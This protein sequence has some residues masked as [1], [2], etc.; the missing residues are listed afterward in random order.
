MKEGHGKF[1]KDITF[2]KL[3]CD[4][5]LPEMHDVICQQLSGEI[6]TIFC[7]NKVMFTVIWSQ[8][9]FNKSDKKKDYVFK[10]FKLEVQNESQGG[11]KSLI[12]TS[13]GL[14]YVADFFYIYILTPNF[15]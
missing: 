9:D 1:I 10:N 12:K 6:E 13:S 11:S 14:P 15:N 4:W 5:N 7:T 8:M 2:L 3:D